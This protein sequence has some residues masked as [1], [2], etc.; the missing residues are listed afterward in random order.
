MKKW[1]LLIIFN[2]ELKPIQWFDSFEDAQKAMKKDF[3]DCIGE[4]VFIAVSEENCGSYFD[5]WSLGDDSAWVS[6]R[7]SIDWYIRPVPTELP[8]EKSEEMLF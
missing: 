5:C 2:R 8:A 4:D 1:M 3:V 7:D 6:D